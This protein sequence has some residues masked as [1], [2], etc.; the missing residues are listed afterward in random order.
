MAIKISALLGSNTN[1]EADLTPALSGNLDTRGFQIIN[2]TGNGIVTIDG[3]KGIQ[4]PVGPQ[5]QRPTPATNGVIR[6]DSD[7]HRFEVFQEDAW[8]NF[9][10][11]LY[12]PGST[13]KTLQDFIN[14]MGSRGTFSG[15]MFTDNGDGTIAVTGG[16]GMTHPID[17]T[18]SSLYFLD[19]PAVSSL[20]LT[21]NALNNIFVDYNNGTPQIIAKTDPD[22]SANKVIIGQVYR[23]GTTLTLNNFTRLKLDNSFVG[24][25]N[26]FQTVNPFQR[27]SGAVISASGVRNFAISAGVFWEGIDR[28]SFTA[29]DTS[30]SDTF[31]YWYRNTPST[32]VSVPN[33]TQINNTQYNNPNTGLATLGNNQYGVHWIYISSDN[34][35]NVIYGITNTSLANSQATDPPPNPPNT[36]LT[37]SL[38]GRIII[39]R[40]SAV[41][42]EV[43]SAFGVAFTGGAVSLH[44]DL[45]GLQGGG[46]NEYYH[47]T[48]AEDA[49]VT[50]LNT[51]ANGILV[52]TGPGVFTPISLTAG[53]G[54]SI[55]NPTG[56]TG[57]PVISAVA[58]ATTAALDEALARITALESRVAALEAILL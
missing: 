40:D 33:Q 5:A 37:T 28:L 18:L 27:E 50:S 52:K 39:Q 15:G 6:Y 46:A 45:G 31:I 41:F 56:T 38:I 43:Q 22:F 51:T 2:S 7:S 19:Y 11:A 36:L 10:D 26:R 14:I 24:I 54:I 57:N 25:I 16:T 32:W 55:T 44:N 20:V 9:T 21:D 48:A 49:T 29:K 1:V 12:L 8:T 42:T 53:T 3:T 30:A 13:Y 34:K 17:D 47:L 23:S 35:I 4:I 58:L